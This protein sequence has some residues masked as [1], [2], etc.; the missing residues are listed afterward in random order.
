[1]DGKQCLYILTWKI[2]SVQFI[3]DSFA[4]VKVRTWVGYVGK[5]IIKIKDVC[6]CT[7]SSNQTKEMAK[8]SQVDVQGIP[9]IKEKASQGKEGTKRCMP[10]KLTLERHGW[11][12]KA[13]KS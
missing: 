1:M 8:E 11:N 10:S 3:G 7:R 12:H 4:S 9:K 2:F 5:Q 13:R 6:V